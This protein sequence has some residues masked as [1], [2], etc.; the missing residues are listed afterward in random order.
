MTPKGA[1][2]PAVASKYEDLRE[3]ETL[4]AVS[5]PPDTDYIFFRDR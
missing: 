1:L 3:V 5:E 4:L 2:N